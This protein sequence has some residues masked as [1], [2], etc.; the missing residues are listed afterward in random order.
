MATPATK[1]FT[2]RLALTAFILA[3]GPALANVT[4]P[5][6]HVVPSVDLCSAPTTPV[7]NTLPGIRCPNGSYAPSPSQCTTVT[8]PSVLCPNGSY[9]PSPSE[10]N[11]TTPVVN[12]PPSVRCPNGNMV[13][14]PSHCP[15]VTPVVNTPASPSA[16][17]RPVS[18]GA[19][20]NTGAA[21][22]AKQKKKNRD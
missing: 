20:V 1:R 5:N 13:P 3:A 17:P 16:S 22:A 10:C 4:C 2:F 19:M 14:N 15:T 12:T 8:P 11:R 18:R 6:G 9:A 7:V 21:R